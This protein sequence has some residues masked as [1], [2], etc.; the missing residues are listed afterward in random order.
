MKKRVK[1]GREHEAKG[2][3][4]RN[5][6]DVA[7]FDGKVKGEVGGKVS[8]GEKCIEVEVGEKGILLVK[9]V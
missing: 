7:K 8:A 1:V 3:L 5:G 6:K 9:K 4:K 2:N